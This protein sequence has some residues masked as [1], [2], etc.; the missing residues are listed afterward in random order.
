MAYNMFCSLV[1]I[2]VNAFL[3]PGIFYEFCCMYVTCQQRVHDLRNNLKLNILK[4]LGNGVDIFSFRE[5]HFLKTSLSTRRHAQLSA[6]RSS[7]DLP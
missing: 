5:K 7:P 6:R 3:L 2:S 4:A 1:I